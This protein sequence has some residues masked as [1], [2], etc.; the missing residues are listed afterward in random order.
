VVIWGGG[1]SDERTRRADVK[2]RKE[3]GAGRPWLARAAERSGGRDGRK[4]AR[5]LD[6]TMRA[7]VPCLPEARKTFGHIRL[8]VTGDCQL[9]D[10][11]GGRR[12][13]DYPLIL[14]SFVARPSTDEQ[15]QPTLTRITG[16]AYVAVE[17]DEVFLLHVS[18][19]YFHCIHNQVSPQRLEENDSKSQRSLTYCSAVFRS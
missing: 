13:H 8:E 16:M 14:T 19:S 9:P 1:P 6:D 12:S 11:K 15:E 3:S 2:R 7:P 10:S 5:M 4:G 18:Y 17:S